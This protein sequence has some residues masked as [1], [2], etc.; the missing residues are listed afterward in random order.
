MKQNRWNS[1]IVWTS[2]GA[3]VLLLLTNYNLLP[4]LGMSEDVF[5][6]IVT[7][8]VSIL[9]MVGV[10]NNPTDKENF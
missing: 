10:L 3:L 2:I 6:Q 4:T 5:N 1:P 8:L 7:S 9:V